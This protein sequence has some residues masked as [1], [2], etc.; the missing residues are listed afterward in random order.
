LYDIYEQMVQ[1]TYLTNCNH[2]S[3]HHFKSV[4]CF[5]L[6]LFRYN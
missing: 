1:K 3:A 5:S 2:E 4:N 6:F